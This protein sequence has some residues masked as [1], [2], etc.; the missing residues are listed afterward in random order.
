M[1]EKRLP[2]LCR[3]ADARLCRK[4][5]GRDA[6]DN[7]DHGKKDQDPE[8]PEEKSPIPGRDADIDDPCHNQR[9][10]QVEQRLQKLERRGENA[11]LFVVCKKHPEFLHLNSSSFAHQGSWFPND[12]IPSRVI[13]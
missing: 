13:Y 10:K 9:H 3:K 5:L 1:I 7:A 8:L 6:A 12:I 2:E 4:V 11:L